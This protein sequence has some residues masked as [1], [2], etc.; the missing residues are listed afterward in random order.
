MFLQAVAKPQPE[1]PN[2]RRVIDYAKTDFDRK[3]IQVG[4][5]DYNPTARPYVLPPGTPKDRV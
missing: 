3:V 1:L 4:I 2:V 5:H